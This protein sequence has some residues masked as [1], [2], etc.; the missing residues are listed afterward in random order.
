MENRD[1]QARVLG[2]ADRLKEAIV[3]LYFYFT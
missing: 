1:P 2:T 3:L